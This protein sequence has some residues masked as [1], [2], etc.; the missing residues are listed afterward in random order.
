[1]VKAPRAFDASAL[2]DDELVVL[3]STLRV[4]IAVAKHVRV[5]QVTALVGGALVTAGLSTLLAGPSIVCSAA[6]HHKCKRRHRACCRALL[7]RNV[8]L[9]PVQTAKFA[10]RA[11]AL[12]VASGLTCCVLGVALDMLFDESVLQ[13]VAF[14]FSTFVE[15]H[16]TQ[17]TTGFVLTR[18]A[19]IVGRDH[20]YVLDDKPVGLLDGLRAV[21]NNIGDSDDSDDDDASG[22]GRSGKTRKRGSSLVELTRRYWKSASWSF[23]A[24]EMQ[25]KVRDAKRAFRHRPSLREGVHSGDDDLDATSAKDDWKHLFADSG[26]VAADDDNDSGGNGLPEHETLFGCHIRTGTTLA[27]GGTEVVD[28]VEHVDLVRTDAFNLFGTCF[29]VRV[30]TATELG[31]PASPATFFPGN[32]ETAPYEPRVEYASGAG[33][34]GQR[35][36]ADAALASQQAHRRA[37][38]SAL[39][40]SGDS[41]S[42]AFWDNI[43][44]ADVADDGDGDG[45]PDGLDDV[46]YGVEVWSYD[47]EPVEAGWDLETAASLVDEN[48][49]V[50]SNRWG[51]REPKASAAEEAFALF[52]GP[53]AAGASS[54]K[55]ASSTGPVFRHPNVEMGDAT[56]ATDAF[57][58]F[59]TEMPRA[60]SFQSR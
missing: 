23:S 21:N 58:L 56:D 57:N 3:E 40:F 30:R 51:E 14:F 34:R 49:F 22:A 12:S 11:L 47:D 39:L 4:Q 38:N 16:I 19:D 26:D 41:E 50:S 25:A 46:E 48:P 52:G 5:L 31:A 20:V 55:A 2:S 43:L 42:C 1:M 17:G 60:S 7:E 15:G 37:H 32:P 54:V 35:E 45:N 6:L 9:A 13:V 36:W 44:K 33:G 18:A 53:G 27:N 29:V 8:P 24:Q 10:K 28:H 59:G